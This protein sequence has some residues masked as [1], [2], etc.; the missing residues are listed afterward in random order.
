MNPK[1]GYL[2]E[3]AQNASVV[4]TLFLWLFAV[5]VGFL[6]AV[7]AGSYLGGKDEVHGTQA[8]IV[9]SGGRIP[10]LAAKLG[11]LLLFS[12][13]VTLVVWL[14]GTLFGAV[15]SAGHQEAPLLSGALGGQLMIVT[16][17]VFLTGLLALTVSTVTRSVVLGNLVVLALLLGQQFLP[18]GLGQALRWVSPFAYF[19]SFTGSVFPEP[20]QVSA[21]TVVPLDATVLQG[22]MCGAAAL[23]TQVLLLVL[24]A[25]RRE[26]RT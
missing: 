14:W 22:L 9:H 11:A 21:V 19:Q 7:V 16:S 25:A 3:R 12:L 10:T 5:L 18:G 15:A 13:A 20:S 8:S 1:S 2:D 23:T 4:S 17:V 26:V 24:L 6:P